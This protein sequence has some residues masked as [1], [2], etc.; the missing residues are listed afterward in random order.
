MEKVDGTADACAGWIGPE[1]ERWRG[2]ENAEREE[3]AR[4]P[5]E[6]RGKLSEAYR[7]KMVSDWVKAAEQEERGTESKL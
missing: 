1:I 6:E 7:V 2:N 4:V 5:R 3:W